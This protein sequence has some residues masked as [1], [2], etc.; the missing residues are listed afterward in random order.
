MQFFLNMKIGFKILAV[1]L[2][3]GA[4]AISVIG[5]ISYDIAGSSLKTESFN[6]L[7]AAREMKA[8]QIESYFQEIRKQVLT[9]SENKMIIDA[10]KEFNKGFNNVDKELGVTDTEMD[11]IDSKLKS[12]YEDEYLKRLNPNLPELAS[13]SDYH[14]TDKN[15]RILQYLYIASNPDKTGSKH[16]LDHPGD[17]GGYSRAHK[18]YHP[19][20]RSYLEKF[21]YYDIFL[22]DVENARIIYS[23]F[24]EVDFGTSLLKGPYKET[25]LAEAYKRA[26]KATNRDSVELKDFAAYHPSYNAQASFIASPIYDGDEKIGVVMF[27]MPVNRINNIM[28]NNEDWEKAGLGKSGETYIIADDHTLRS[29]SRFLIEDEQNYYKAIKEAGASQGMINTIKKL[30]SPIGLQE[31]KTPGAESAIGGETGSGIFKDYRNVPVLSSYK[32]LNIED[33]KWNI[34]SEIDEAEAFEHVYNLRNRIFWCAGIL[35]AAMGGIVYAFSKVI[36]NPLARLSNTVI[37]VEH[38]GDFSKRIDIVGRDEVGRTVNA[39]N[40]LMNSLESAVV[41]ITEVVKAFSKGNFTESMSVE[42]KGDLKAVKEGI[43]G[44]SNSISVAID[45]ISETISALG[46]GVFDYHNDVK[47][48]GELGFMKERIDETT[49]SISTIMGDI[50]RVMESVAAGD[51]T[52]RVTIEANG[53]LNKLKE[54]INSSICDLSKT[55]SNTMEK[56]HHVAVAAGQSSSAV[57]QISEGAQNQMRSI[58]EIAATINQTNTSTD[59]VCQNVAGANMNAQQITKN[60]NNCKAKIDNLVEIVR[61]IAQNSEEIGKIT[62]VIE[63]IANKTNMLSLNAAIEAAGAGE[64]GKGFAVVADEV[65]KLAEQSANSAQNIA[66]LIEQA[67]NETGRAVSSVNEVDSDMETITVEVAKSDKMLEQIASITEKQSRAMQQVSENV[68]TL[69]QI[70]ETNATATEEITATV[71]DLSRLAQETKDE[72]EKFRLNGHCNSIV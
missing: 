31:V 62:D 44:S 61:V 50:N 24:K 58:S 22:T 37:E 10:V 72:I 25:N 5:Y 23:V 56:T 54:R 15:A 3:L 32:P 45:S 38:T 67:V 59:E 6:K 19:I 12:Y 49:K 4:G 20:I 65:R 42:V 51:L 9:F 46:H 68:T 39:F 41:G 26:K 28:T 66:G 53:D 13:Y 14:P 70:G 7:T 36:T 18:K 21:G 16:K 17:V 55:L 47:L 35:M 63:T 40:S 30:G 57:G 52:Q 71:M 43:N 11:A 2:I 48:E 27:Q 8:E 34:M 33:V 29:Q 60:V 1:F 64:H 69:N